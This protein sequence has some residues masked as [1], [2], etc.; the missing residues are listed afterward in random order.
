MNYSCV[1]PC[2]FDAVCHVMYLTLSENDIQYDDI[3]YTA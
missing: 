1:V 3:F 2:G